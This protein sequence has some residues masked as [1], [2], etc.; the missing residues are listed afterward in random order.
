MIYEIYILYKENKMPLAHYYIK[1]LPIDN[2]QL[3]SGFLAAL[4]NFASEIGER[5]IESLTFKTLKFVYGYFKEIFIVFIVD[6]PDED[7]IIKDKIRSVGEAFLL[8][9]GNILDDWDGNSDVFNE[10][11]SIV[12][13]VIKSVLKIVLLGSGGVG[14]TTI[15]KLLKGETIPIEHIPTIGAG[16]SELLISG[17]VKLMVW[18]IAGQN[19]FRQIWEDFIS[20]ADIIFLVTDST[21][22]NLKE[23]KTIYLLYKEKVEPNCNFY[24][25]ANKQDLPNA[26]SP[27]A[28]EEELNIK[29]KKLLPYRLVQIMG[30]VLFDTKT[31]LM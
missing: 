7:L 27:K 18:D 16:I 4:T 12:R 6:K 26:I 30:M 15:S 20:G 3:V 11:D 10:F 23:T 25:I 5:V 8:K 17:E 29:T 9:Y 31:L 19:R 24:A 13:S 22:D 28:V 21:P 14:K 1:Q 2:T